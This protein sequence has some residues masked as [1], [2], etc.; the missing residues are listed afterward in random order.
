MKNF[1]WNALFLMMF[2]G[3]VLPPAACGQ[4]VSLTQEERAWLQ[5]HPNIVLGYT[6][7]FEP[8]VIVGP[9][10]T[11]R[12]IQVDILDELNRRLGTKIGLQIY[13]V[14]ELIEKAQQ[15]EVDGILNLHPGYAD[16][17]GLLK[18]GDYFTGYP[19]VFARKDMPCE[20]P[21]D[22]AGKRV[23]IIDK[24]FFSEQIIGEYGRG[25]TILKVEDAEE[26]LQLIDNGQ[27]D[28]FLGATLNAYL[29]T[30]YQLFDLATQYVFYDDRIDGVIGTRSDWPELS[31]ILDKG[32]SSFSK[33]EIE[34]ITAKW[35]SLSQQLKPIGLTAEERSWL[36][37]GHTVR[38]RVG[39]YPPNSFMTDGKP[40]GIAIDLLKEVSRRSGIQFDFVSY[41]IPFGEALTRLTEHSGPD[42]LPSIQST[43]EREKSILFTDPYLTHPKFIFTKDDAPFV[44]SMEDLSGKKVAVERA[45]V[46]R[47]LLEKE[48]P[49]INLRICETT[50]AA[51][52]T[53]SSGEA[54][55]YIGPIRPTAVIINKH[56]F[57]NLKAAAPSSLPDNVVRMGIRNDWPEL[58]SI[59]NK[60]LNSMPE[61]KKS[62]IISRWTPIRF[63]HGI[64]SSDIVKWVLGVSGAA[65]VIVLI[66]VSWNRTLHRAVRER[67]AAVVDREES[68]KEA[69]QLARIGSWSWDVETDVVKWSKTMREL[70]GW[71]LDSPPPS[72]EENR[73]IYDEGSWEQLTHAVERAVELA[74]PYELGLSMKRLDGKTFQAIVRGK[75]VKDETGR[76]VRLHGTIQDITERKRVEVRLHESEQKFRD[77][78][79]QSP[80]VFELYDTDGVLIEV[81]PAFEKLWNL[82]KDDVIGK[83]NVFESA[84]VKKA[85][86]IPYFKRAFSGESVSPPDTEFDASLEDVDN[87]EK[88]RKRWVSSF[89]YPVNDMNGNVT[90]VVMMHEDIT[91]R[92]RA[93]ENL[94]QMRNYTD[95]L[96]QTANVMIVSLNSAGQVTHF[97]PAAEVITGYTLSDMEGGNWFET[98]VPRDRYPHVY[99]EF[100][101]LM[102]GGL[103]KSFENPIVTKSGEERHISWTNSEIKRGDEIVG[104]T[105][106]GIDITE[107][108]KAERALKESETQFRELVEQSPISIQVLTP[109]GRITMVNQ[110]FKD[111]WGI[112]EDNLSEVLDKYNML[113]DEEAR[114]RGVM[115]LI[116]KAFQ[117]ETVTLPVIEYDAATAMEA[118]NVDTKASKVWL[119]ARLYP[120]KNSGGEVVAVVDMEEDI[121]NRKQAEQKVQQ[122][123]QRLRALAS[124]LTLAEESERRRIAADLHDHVQQSLASA[125]LQLAA[126][127]K[128]QPHVKLTATLDA[129][130]DSLR[131]TLQETRQLVFDLS[132]P[133]MN[134]IGLGAAIS[135]WLHEQVEQRHGLKTEFADELRG[136]SMDED[137]RAILFR[138]VRELLA[139]AIK[140]AQAT[141]I[142]V[143]LRS[144]N[145]YLKITVQDDGVGC[146]PDTIQDTMGYQGGF[147]LFSIRERMSDL[148]GELEITS[149][150]G[151]GCRVV[152]TAPLRV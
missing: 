83:F 42:L 69:Q 147:G 140:H 131:D 89:I 53:V 71:D 52:Q 31:V 122:Y 141:T 24:V 139:N 129:V 58:R 1:P 45:Y 106:F 28:F 73:R 145:G 99:D 84:Q 55:A 111:L 10:G 87:R 8:D 142:S 95:H 37:Q 57:G 150:P 66:F 14:Q 29:I 149:E 63:E 134:E 21:S 56:G 81:N 49:G 94:E 112:A 48:Y 130:S 36:E 51:L 92:K 65:L 3:Y 119:Q 116:E 93:Q 18:T 75:A 67:T 126:A 54:F 151:K 5:T 76:V 82:S 61:E 2:L 16:E 125:R 6:G 103:P 11:L 123:Q 44:T 107:R 132:S 34:A 17:L 13:P 22:L 26:A 127:R 62:G 104:I 144:E 138:S 12:G 79:E 102:K 91:E 118:L 85:G 4:E 39:D 59:I 143:A 33:E 27:A 135:E 68:L 110:A 152:L 78:V 7:A 70:V 109:D 25:A 97:N 47:K 113:E 117:G 60:A 40:A 41:S 101:R 9:D 98:L 20:G 136:A 96:I 15:K 121:T 148:G 77:L 124:Q 137:V 146:D 38:V 64:R 43:S 35:S 90:H 19:A 120:V 72:H 105:S 32:L 46:M 86:L 30:K 100:D 74:E 23:A 50:R 108:M 133:S 88:S 128:P 80:V 115:P 114:R